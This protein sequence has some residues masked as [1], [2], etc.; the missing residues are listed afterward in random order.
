M[1]FQRYIKSTATTRVGRYT[2]ISLEDIDRVATICEMKAIKF[3]EKS[4]EY[5]RGFLS[6][7]A[8]F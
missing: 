5:C 1:F 4:G 7:R 6:L 3:L 8:K 2:H